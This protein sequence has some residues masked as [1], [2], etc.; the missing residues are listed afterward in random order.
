[1]TTA[2]DHPAP[3]GARARRPSSASSTSAAPTAR[4]RPPCTR[5][6]TCRSPSHPGELVALVGR[7]GS[8][9]TTLLNVHRR[10]GPARRGPRGRRRARGVLARRARP[11]RAAPRRRLV[12]VPDVRPGPGAVRGRERRRAAAAAQAAD[13][14]PRGAGRSCCSTSSGSARTRCSGPASCPAVSSSAS[15][16]PGRWPTPRACW[17]PTSRPASSTPRPARP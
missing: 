16:S 2:T 3:T 11:G 10:P 1:M 9:K 15:R 6:G 12:R 8:G 4:A 5:C 14:G 13:R 7:S 17:S